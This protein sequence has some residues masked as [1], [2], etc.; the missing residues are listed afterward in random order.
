MIE[1]I[2][3]VQ[4]HTSILI[5]SNFEKNY[6]LASVWRLLSGNEGLA[7]SQGRLCRYSPRASWNITSNEERRSRVGE[8]S[9]RIGLGLTRNLMWVQGILPM[10]PY[11]RGLIPDTTGDFKIR[12]ADISGNWYWWGTQ[13]GSG[14][15]YLCWPQLVPSAEAWTIW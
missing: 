5:S 13:S 6:L 1:A 11:Q 9:T 14:A 2:L 7:L 8:C 3:N 12:E 15:L 10:E 4:L